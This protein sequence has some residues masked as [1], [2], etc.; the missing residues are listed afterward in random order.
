MSADSH[1]TDMWAMCVEIAHLR[2]EVERMTSVALARYDKIDVLAAQVERDRPVVQ[3]AIEYVNGL[4][5]MAA[6]DKLVCAVAASVP[7]EVNEAER[8][9]RDALR[10]KYAAIH[11]VGPPT[12][13]ET[14]EGQ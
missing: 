2:S 13:D 5:S 10:L 3:A 6:L 1:T 9:R 7:V 8:E 14:N 11:V 12:S 4:R